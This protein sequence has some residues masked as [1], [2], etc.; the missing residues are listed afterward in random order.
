MPRKLIFVHPWFRDLH[1]P[2]HG[3]VPDDEQEAESDAGSDDSTDDV[4]ASASPLYAEPS[5]RVDTLIRALRMIAR[6]GCPFNAL[7]LEQ[8]PNGQYK[9]VAA[10]HEIIVPGL[11]FKTNPKDIR[12][13]VLEIV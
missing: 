7:L 9:R 2:L 12:A 13:K 6:L 8:Q 1:D 3:F 10:E 4:S 5:P 11:Q